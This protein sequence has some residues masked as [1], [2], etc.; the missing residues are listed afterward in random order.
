LDAP[1]LIIAAEFNSVYVLRRLLE[2]GAKVDTRDTDGWTP[3]MRAVQFNALECANSLLAA[4]A[5]PKLRNYERETALDIAIKHQAKDCSQEES[6]VTPTLFCPNK[7]HQHIGFCDQAFH[8]S[9]YIHKVLLSE[10]RARGRF[11]EC[12]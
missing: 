6:E 5:N 9:P 12:G 10:I 11:A 4:G 8:S 3:L 1:P 2:A 7:K